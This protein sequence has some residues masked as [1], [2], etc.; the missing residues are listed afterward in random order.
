MFS[1]GMC[2]S[3][4]VQADWHGP[5][6]RTWTARAA[7]PAQRA[8]Y[9]PT[10]PP[11][12]SETS[13]VSALAIAQ[14][15]TTANPRSPQR[16]RMVIPPDHRRAFARRFDRSDFR[17]GAKGRA[18]ARSS[19]DPAPPAVDRVARARLTSRHQHQYVLMHAYDLDP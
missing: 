5:T 10:R 4:T 7:S 15:A 17:R 12:L 2:P 8:S 13:I 3:S 19:A 11:W 9:S 1:R 18:R 16:N 6:I 14:R